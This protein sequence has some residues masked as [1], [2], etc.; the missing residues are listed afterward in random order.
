MSNAISWVAN[1]ETDGE[2]RLELMKLAGRV[3]LPGKKNE[4]PFVEAEA[5]GAEWRASAE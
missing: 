4:I 2:K 3:L 1:K 5:V